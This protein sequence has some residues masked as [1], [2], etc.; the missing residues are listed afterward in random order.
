M[1]ALEQYL[2]IYLF[3]IYLIRCRD[4][5]VLCAFL[6]VDFIADSILYSYFGWSVYEYLILIT[7]FEITLLFVALQFVRD[8]VIKNVFIFCYIPTLLCPLFLF[9]LD[10]WI[11]RNDFLS[12]ILFFFCKDVGK[13]S[14]EI[15]LTYLLY[16]KSDKSLKG[17]Y[18]Q[19]FILANYVY[20][21]V[22]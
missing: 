2:V 15:F 22:R 8:W 9:T 7:L 17:T 6:T 1:L 10:H 3:S 12:N 21:F 19:V 14:N 20:A 18:W 13:Y 5:K 16:K 11:T 4:V